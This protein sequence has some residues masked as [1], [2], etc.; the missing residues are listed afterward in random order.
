ML[1]CQAEKYQ[2]IDPEPVNKM[3]VCGGHF[4]RYRAV[5]SH[6]CAESPCKKHQQHHYDNHYR[7]WKLKFY[8]YNNENKYSIA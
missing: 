2:Q 6:P 8:Y 7:P 3:P 1:T 4:D 5:G